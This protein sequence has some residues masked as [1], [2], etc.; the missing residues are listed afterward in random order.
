MIFRMNYLEAFFSQKNKKNIVYLLRANFMTPLTCYFIL[1]EQYQF[2]YQMA[3]SYLERQP[4]S[5]ERQTDKSTDKTASLLLE[6][7]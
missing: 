2:C 5:I 3:L 4:I 6:D 7:S 1:Q